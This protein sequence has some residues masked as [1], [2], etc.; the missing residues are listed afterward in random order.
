M[1]GH[2]PRA[3]GRGRRELRRQMLIGEFE[4]FLRKVVRRG[5]IG[6]RIEGTAEFGRTLPP[7]SIAI[8]SLIISAPQA[9]DFDSS[10][11]SILDY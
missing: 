10:Q 7:L 6:G 2:S 4:M 9:S 3:K 1:L 11:D 8:S 5:F